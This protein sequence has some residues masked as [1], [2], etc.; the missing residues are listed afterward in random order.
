MINQDII[1]K[2]DYHAG[3]NGDKIDKEQDI[4]HECLSGFGGSDEA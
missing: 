2:V 4:L 3:C 1:N